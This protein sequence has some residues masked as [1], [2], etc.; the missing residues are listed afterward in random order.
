LKGNVKL[1][2]GIA[3]LSAALFAVPGDIARG[4]GTYDV[5]TQVIDLRGDLAM[6]A[7]LSKAAGGFK[8]VLL[9]PLDPLF[10]KNGA[11]SVLPVRISGTYSHPMFKASLRR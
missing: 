4:T 9:I 2:D 1:R 7:S 11:G 5:T 3:T 6:H 10:K 8:S